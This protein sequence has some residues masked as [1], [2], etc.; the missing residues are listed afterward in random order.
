MALVDVGLT[1]LEFAVRCPVMLPGACD[2]KSVELKVTD[3]TDL[4]PTEAMITKNG[5]YWIQTL[6]QM[7]T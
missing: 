2:H 6:S 3:A 1:E 4:L 7:R 5:T